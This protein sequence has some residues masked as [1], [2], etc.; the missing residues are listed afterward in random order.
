MFCIISN[1][2]FKGSWY[3]N[4]KKFKNM[5]AHLGE[6]EVFWRILLPNQIIKTP[7]KLENLLLLVPSFLKILIS[8]THAL[9]YLYFQK[10]KPMWKNWVLDELLKEKESPKPVET[11]P[12]LDILLDLVYQLKMVIIAFLTWVGFPLGRVLKNL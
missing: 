10:W 3:F 2:N 1:K 12:K 6:K 9:D 11:T 5:K 8:S 4:T 7:Y